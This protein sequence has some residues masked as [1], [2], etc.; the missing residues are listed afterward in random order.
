MSVTDYAIIVTIGILSAVGQY[1]LKVGLTTTMNT[2]SAGPAGLI[3]R[4]VTNPSLLLAGVAYVFAFAIY[5]LV[6]AKSD[7]SQIFP[8]AIG[9]NVL[10][11]ALMAAVILGEAVTLPRLVG[12]AAIVIGVYVVTRF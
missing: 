5:L 11:V 3:I 1:L 8:V 7:V 9:V 4:A 12:M 6:L 10:C 2:A